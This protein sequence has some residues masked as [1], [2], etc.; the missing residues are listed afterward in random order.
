[1]DMN[2]LRI[3]K[4]E[5]GD[6]SLEAV[7]AALNKQEKNIVG[8]V[9]WAEYPYCPDVSFQMGYTVDA[10]HLKFEVHEK[11]VRAVNDQPN[12]S[13]WEDSCCEFF[14]D[15]D[16]KGYYNLETNCIGTQLLG[17]GAEKA[18]REH[19]SADLIKTIRVESSLGNKP[20]D[21]KIGDF[22]YD[23][24]MSIPRGAFYAH[25]L[26]F[27]AGMKFRANFYKCGDETP[28]MHFVSWNPIGVDEPNFHLPDFFGEVHLI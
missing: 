5:V 21:T 2:E 25:D 24:V 27:E 28:D 3:A 8:V 7:S 11:A 19:A 4:L 26:T 20:F 15:F 12:G 13:V 16:G 1:M 23:V 9:N 14:C 10:L 17:W 22:S 18:D 6:G